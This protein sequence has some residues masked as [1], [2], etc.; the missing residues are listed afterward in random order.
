MGDT[1]L[2]LHAFSLAPFEPLDTMSLKAVSYKMF[3][4]S[5]L[6]LGACRGELC[7]LRHGQFVRPAEDWSVVLLFSDSFFIPITAKGCL[8]TAPC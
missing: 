1:G 3:V 6:A 2:V 4:F 7:A 8:P 5:A